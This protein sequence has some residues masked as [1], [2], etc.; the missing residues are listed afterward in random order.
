MDA[1]H[2]R[3]RPILMTTFAMG[4][5]MVPVA[6]GLGADVEFRSPMAIAVLGGLISSTF[7]SLLYIP[8]IFTIVDDLTRAFSRRMAP[9]FAAQHNVPGGEPKAGAPVPAE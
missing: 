5:G 9:M 6:I 8:A 4:A 1:A 2:K 7:L 3:A